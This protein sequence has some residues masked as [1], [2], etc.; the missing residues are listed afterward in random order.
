MVLFRFAR[1]LVERLDTL[2]DIDVNPVSSKPFGL[3]STSI[4]LDRSS[5]VNKNISVIRHFRVVVS[6]SKRGSLVRET[7]IPCKLIDSMADDI[8]RRSIVRATIYRGRSSKIYG[9]FSFYYHFRFDTLSIS[10][11]FN[12][13]LVDG[14]IT[15][16][17]VHRL[18]LSFEGFY[19]FVVS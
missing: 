4:D 3:P 13:S 15:R 8:D 18:F 10:I 12:Y 7:P 9:K 2:R 16:I 6:I 14:A 17:F 11:I 1:I 19:D 5:F